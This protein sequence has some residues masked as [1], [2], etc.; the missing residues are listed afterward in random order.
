MTS[1]KKHL[2][3]DQSLSQIESAAD[4]I[5]EHSLNQYVSERQREERDKL[6]REK[7]NIDNMYENLGGRVFDLNADLNM[8]EGGMIMFRA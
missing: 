4:Q 5:I 1:S 6:D 3:E 2:S 8:S 7:D